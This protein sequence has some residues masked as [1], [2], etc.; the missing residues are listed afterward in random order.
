M[1]CLCR[2]VR[3][4]SRPGGHYAC[5]A[6]IHLPSCVATSLC[7]LTAVCHTKRKLRSPR[8]RIFAVKVG[9]LVV[10]TAVGD[11][12]QHRLTHCA[13]TSVRCAPWRCAFPSAATR[14]TSS[15]ALRG[16]T[17]SSRRRRRRSPT[18]T[19][20]R[21]ARFSPRSG[22]APPAL[23]ASPP[24]M[25]SLGRS[26]KPIHGSIPQ[27]PSATCLNRPERRAS[28]R[29]FGDALSLSPSAF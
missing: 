6:S 23:L 16:A 27:P 8:L 22:A 25:D 28:D 10:G 3:V 12:V 21:C 7:N 17:P 2:R 24:Q 13:G 19:S 5:T 15:S 9:R 18:S 1:S 29:R 20:K 14:S 4:C 26:P 11:R